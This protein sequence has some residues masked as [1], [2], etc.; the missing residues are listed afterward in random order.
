V[1]CHVWNLE[2]FQA[3]LWGCSH[4]LLIVASIFFLSGSVSLGTQHDL[5]GMCFQF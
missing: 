4:S 5:L 2:C 1:C 3:N